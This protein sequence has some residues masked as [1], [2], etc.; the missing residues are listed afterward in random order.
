M[1]KLLIVG[2]GGHGKVVAD[3]A[4]ALSF[5]DIY[6][7]DTAWPK[8]T[9]NGRWEIIGKPS[10]RSTQ[11]FV[12]LGDNYLRERIF[13]EFGLQQSPMLVH[14]S[15]IISPSVIVGAGTIIVAGAIVNADAKIG[16]GAILN[17]ACSV[18][19]DCTIGNFTHISPGVH[20]AGGVSVGDRTW[21]GIG[22]VV[23]EGVSIGKN[24]IIGGGSVVINN[25]EDNVRVRGI[26]ASIF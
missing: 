5:T 3:T 10:R 25:I 8:L 11:M 22:A 6:F 18:D 20:L 9:K 26:P 15:A 24:V 21:I 1:T 4:E 12:A 19:H 17:T 13:N 7:L 23:H 16:D 2:G 14:P